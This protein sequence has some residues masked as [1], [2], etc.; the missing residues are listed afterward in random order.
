MNGAQTETSVCLNQSSRRSNRL[1]YH[2]PV[3]HVGRLLDLSQ[4]LSSS[5][6]RETVCMAARCE[7]PSETV[8][9]AFKHEDG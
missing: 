4:N 2:K 3:K 9:E 1:F 8:L 6:P 7:T 5:C